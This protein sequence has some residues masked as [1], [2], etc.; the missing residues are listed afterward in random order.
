MTHG[1]VTPEQTTENSTTLRE[2]LTVNS[3]ATDLGGVLDLH[4]VIDA[5]FRVAIVG[6]QPDG[7]DALG[8]PLLDMVSSLLRQPLRHAVERCVAS[9]DTERVSLRLATS[10][11]TEFAAAIGPFEF[12]DG[13]GLVLTAVENKEKNAIPSD[14]EFQ[15]NVQRAVLDV[16]DIVVF[17]KDRE[18]RFLGANEKLVSI[19]GADDVSEVLG[20]TDFDF[21][22]AE[23]AEQYRADDESVMATGVPV[24]DRV[25]T[26]T[27]AEGKGEILVT[28]KLPVRDGHGEVIGVTGYFRFVTEAVETKQELRSLEG[29]HALA[30]Q[31]SHEGVWELDL[32]T[33]KFEV[34]ERFMQLVGLSRSGGRRLSPAALSRIFG[35]EGVREV[36]EQ[37][38]AVVRNPNLQLD[39]KMLRAETDLG[40]RWFEATG[41]PF[42]E[43]GR[44]AK[45]VGTLADITEEIE[46][47]QR[48]L[49]AATHDDL[50]GLANRRQLM[51]RLDEELEA[52]ERT[53]LLYL[54]LD[55]FKVVND[56]L[57]H[58]VGDELLQSV[59]QRLS[60]I[61]CEHC[62]FARL[63]GDEFAIVGRSIGTDPEALAAEILQA[64]SKPLVLT[65]TEV[66]TTASIGLVYAEGQVRGSVGVLRDADT[67]L[68]EAKAAGKNCVQVFEPEMRLAADRQLA[69]QNRIRRG[70]DEKQFE[71]LYQPVVVAGTGEVTAVE[72]LLRWNTGGELVPP[73][74]FLPYL[75]QSGLIVGVGEQV[76]R[77]SVA[78]LAT[79]RKALPGADKLVCSLNLSRVQFR[80]SNLVDVLLESLRE[81][82]VPPSRLI[83]EVTETA[84]SDD[85]NAM[86]TTLEKLRSLGIRVAVDDFGV[87]QSSLSSLYELPVDVL[88]IDSA[89]VQR[90]DGKESQ[91]VIEAIIAMGHSVG[92]T[93]V[94]EGVETQAQSQFLESAG[95]DYLQGY[96]FGRPMSPD[97][98]ATHLT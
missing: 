66:Y 14:I 52:N 77:D 22:P 93:L 50:T 29:R 25:E 59:S 61:V 3:H 43:Q 37:V 63:G 39:V 60:R 75:E 81:H 4:W 18:G 94:A 74:V 90:I 19:I 41:Y 51:E 34:N 56:S 17:W 28:T 70:F 91:P 36:T 27:T 35:T 45:V 71:L 53:F 86:V 20:K 21:F 31:A 73:G 87:G 13:T 24:I 82:H 12:A 26:L 16:M 9:G 5:K 97:A 64:L 38:R 68:Y 1:G 88:K 54:D 55:Q 96:F 62:L 80:S 23:E 15:L 65:E 92:L 76:I 83:V 72:A 33:E 30:L 7:C 48:L 2:F 42:V 8:R 46:R 95:C 79:W 10:P 32:E 89:F 58:G 98:I 44:V 49:Y 47:D 78:Q 40:S 57:G 67:A 69:L 11:E 84:V 85:V 6:A